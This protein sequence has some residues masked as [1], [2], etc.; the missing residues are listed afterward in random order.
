M[1]SEQLLDLKP[2]STKVTVLIETFPSIFQTHEIIYA[3]KDRIVGLN[4]GRWDY[5]YSM[6]KSLN[7]KTEFPDR[8]TLTMDQP[9]LEAYVEQIVNT[10]HQRGI[11]AMGGMSAFIPTKDT[12]EN[13]QIMKKILKDKELEIERGC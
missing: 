6:M 12:E 13:K 10:C 3:L 2:N 9:F 8:N 1:G 11:H 5:I 4:C 7:T